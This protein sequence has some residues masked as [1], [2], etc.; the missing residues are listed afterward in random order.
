MTKCGTF[1]LCLFAAAAC[2]AQ[3]TN[4][5]RMHA[6]T[7]REC[8]ACHPAQANPHPAT[9]MAHALEAP[10]ECK[11]LIE[12]PVLTFKDGSYSYRIERNGA[13]SIYTVTDGQE[14]FSAPIS[15]AFG[16]GVAGQTYVYEKDGALYQSRVSFYDAT[17]G[18]DLTIGA[19]NEKP[20]NLAE[21]AGHLMARDEQVRC[22]G[23]HA[24]NAVS[25]S[26]VA[27]DRMVP[28]IQCERCHGSSD[29]HLA[30]VKGNP[31]QPGPSAMRSLRRMS[32]EDTANFCGQ[33]HR[34]WDDIAA[35]GITGIANIRF[36]PYRLTN[37]K[38]YDS[39]DRRIRCTAC[40]DPHREI[41]R[42]DADYD[43]K[44]Q[45]CHSGGGKAAARICK[46]GSSSCA[47]CHMP[48]LDLPGTHHQFTDHN[49]RIVRAHA[50]Y[51]D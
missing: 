15:W 48:K 16:L 25:G 35:S 4:E 36:Q 42:T 29:A 33:C 32:S 51:P 43:P 26:Q 44:C 22:F 39:E 5:V 38:C 10:F 46:V 28:G 3:D 17:N 50:K 37:S 31:S 20:A 9:S 47:T 7:V 21:A 19:G 23:C 30:A 14:V 34:R 6:R 12:H 24:T 2:F 11:I 8:A 40:H 45:A 13:R 27:F 1:L 41:S 18:L 49:I